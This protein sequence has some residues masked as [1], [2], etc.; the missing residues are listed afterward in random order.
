MNRTVNGPCIDTR[1]GVVCDAAFIEAKANILQQSSVND[2]TVQF[3]GVD[4]AR[5]IGMQKGRADIPGIAADV[6]EAVAGVNVGQYSS[7]LTPVALFVA[8]GISR[9]EPGFYIERCAHF[10]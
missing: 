1:E 5:H 3:D 8:F 6:Q 7:Y 4:L 10:G 9:I 2:G